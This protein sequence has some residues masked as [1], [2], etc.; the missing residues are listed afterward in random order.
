M[1]NLQH[2]NKKV[3]KPRETSCLYSEISLH[4]GLSLRLHTAGGTNTENVNIEVMNHS[5]SGR[6]TKNVVVG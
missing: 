4:G 6:A 1:V 5:T 3:G 2:L